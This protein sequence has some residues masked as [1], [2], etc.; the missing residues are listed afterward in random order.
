MP[1]PPQLTLIAQ[2]TLIALSS[3]FFSNLLQE[4]GPLP[5]PKSGLL[6]DTQP[7]IVWEDTCADKDRD[8]A[9]KGLL[10][11]EWE[12]K[13]TQEDCSTMWLAV[14]GFMVMGLVSRLTLVNHSDSGSFLVE[15]TSLSQ[16]GVQCEGFW[17]VDR[18]CGVSSLLL[19]FLELF[20][21]VE[22]C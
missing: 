3:I 6:S 5:G 14:L 9:G 15:R 21:L 11:G 19:T 12:G 22:A 8:F 18:I 2:E 20:W 17:E 7:W 10:R 13:G 4:G 16:D 1:W